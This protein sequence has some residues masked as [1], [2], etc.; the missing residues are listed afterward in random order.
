MFRLRVFCRRQRNA[1]TVTAD[2]MK[3][4]IRQMP[5]QKC[6]IAVI[7]KIYCGDS[8]QGRSKSCSGETADC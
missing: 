8:F 1:S 4:G 3:L 5:L 7:K 6:E 2:R